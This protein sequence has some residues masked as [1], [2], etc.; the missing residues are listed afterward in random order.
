MQRIAVVGAGSIGGS[1]GGLLTK[2]RLDVTLLD[3]W[4]EHVRAMQQHGLTIDGLKEQHRVGVRVTHWDDLAS[5]TGTF[6]VVILSTRAYDTEQAVRRMLPFL[7]PDSVVVSAQNGLCEEIIAPIIGARRTLGC[8]VMLSARV[9]GAGYLYHLDPMKEMGRPAV[10]DFKLGELDGRETPRLHHLEALFSHAGWTTTTDNLWGE[11]W[12][13]LTLNSMNNA[14]AGVTGLRAVQEQA[15]CRAL[16]HALAAESVRVGRTLGYRI[17]TIED[18][19]TLDA[20]E[21]R[22]AQALAVLRHAARHGVAGVTA[23]AVQQQSGLMRDLLSG[24]RTEVDYLNGYIARRGA[25]IGVPAP[26]NAAATAVVKE[27]EA[28]TRQIGLHNVAHI[29]AMASHEGTA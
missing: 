27:I 1:I 6:D 28:G 21:E 3:P 14:V 18:G 25:A 11:R 24:R 4:T 20:M 16:T 7:R 8:V 5:V 12:A 9:R 23:P 22:G 10:P 13:K 2:A 15:E 29:A 26:Y 17:A 19:V